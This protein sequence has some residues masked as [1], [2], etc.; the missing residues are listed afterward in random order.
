MLHIE[1]EL[2]K[3]FHR[4]GEQCI[5]INDYAINQMLVSFD[6]ATRI[7]IVNENQ[8][9]MPLPLAIEPHQKDMSGQFETL[10]W[11]LRTDFCETH[12][13]LQSPAINVMLAKFTHA[14]RKR[15]NKSAYAQEINLNRENNPTWDLY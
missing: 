8:Q 10:M 2:T 14:T 5:E 6:D 9:T 3:F 13:V 15:I 1:T 7:R 12:R 4:F 11:K